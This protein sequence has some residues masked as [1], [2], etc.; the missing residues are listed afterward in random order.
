MKIAAF[1]LLIIISSAGYSNNREKNEKYNETYRNQFHFSPNFNKMGSPIACWENDSTYHMYYQHNPYN[2]LEGYINWA[3]ASST[4]LIHWKQ[5]ELILS[6]PANISDSMNMVPWWGSVT[7]A[8]GETSAWFNKWD[9]GVFKAPV[10]TDLSIENEEKIAL[11]DSLT[12][13]DPF[14]FWHRESNKWVMFAYNRPSTTMH[15]LNSENGVSWK[16]TSSFNY[17]Y[18]FP[19][20]F[21][22]PI[23][24][25]PD[26]TRWVM[27]TEG[28]TYIL[29]NFDGSTFEI[30][31][32]VKKFN[33]G[34][35]LGGT[36]VLND[37]T[38]NRFILFTSV[39]S[40][41]M[42]DLPSNGFL[43]FPAEA[44]LHEGITG[45]EM[46]L[47]PVNEIEILFDK[48]KQWEEKKIYPGIS[49][50]NLL[51]RIKGHELHIKADIEIINSDNFGFL[52]R[53]NREGK[54]AE[55]SYN[56]RRGIFNI[57]NT[58]IEYKPENNK[59]EFEILVDRSCIEV[60]IDGGKL[61]FS[62]S[63]TPLPESN[64]YMLYT[65]GGEIFVNK[66]EVTRLKSMWE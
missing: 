21:E 18:G 40:K 12:K 33:H 62:S 56:V 66:L 52:I 17:N 7:K 43:S 28:G 44:F 39:K 50:S 1:I 22:M 58:Q 5:E 13:C 4:D 24:R 30:E 16:K 37:E 35:D 61:V 59:L 31:S 26:D 23:N 6:Q 60:Y 65:S 53:G 57:L 20:V 54:G 45:I 19:Q 14:V 8:E 47:K 49:R 3:H 34:R 27:I 41:Q 51:R 10:A 64:M 32:T 63:F 15:I 29:G 46:R 48:G 36:V 11:P 38:N 2:L 25:R 9:N 42:A 55:I